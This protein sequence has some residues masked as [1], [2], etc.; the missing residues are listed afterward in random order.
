MINP[1]TRFK[2]DGAEGILLTS[3]QGNLGKHFSGI[4]E[5][6]QTRCFE[7]TISL[8]TLRF[9][10]DVTRRHSQSSAPVVSLVFFVCPM[11]ARNDWTGIRLSI[12]K[13][14]PVP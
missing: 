10:F 13:R 7:N 6:V 14:R 1:W 9:A 8:H 4:Y 3:F 2:G 11:P 12:W 5:I